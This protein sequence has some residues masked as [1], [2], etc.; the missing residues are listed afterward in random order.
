MRE[1]EI[2]G[3]GS[4]LIEIHQENGYQNGACGAWLSKVARAVKHDT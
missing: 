1:L 3:W 2:N 4:R